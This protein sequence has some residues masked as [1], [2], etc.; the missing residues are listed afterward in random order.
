MSLTK[1][2]RDISELSKNAQ[3]ACRLFLAECQ[4]QGLN[5][6][7]TETYRSQER[8]NYLYEQGRTRSGKIVTWTHKSRHTS[9]RAWDICQ[10]IKGREY[11]D[12]AFF[13]SCGDVAKKLNITWGG[14]WKTP[15]TP[16][17]EIS[18]NWKKPNIK[19]D[20][21][22]TVEERIKFNQL[23][24]RVSELTTEVDRLKECTPKVY[25]YGNDVPEW[26]RVALFNA[27]QK[28]IFK[29]S[30]ADDLNVSE[31]TL[32]V[33]VYFERLGLI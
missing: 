14:N 7:I 33:L 4:K 11:S 32:K 22:M 13:K 8:Q 24:N 26:A 5:V 21:E 3:E 10:N 28:G 1:A 25:H 30:S 16:H 19:G 23:V 2:C 20:E 18:E 9:R 29:G 17:F 31:D 12:N 15:D 27:M 6:L